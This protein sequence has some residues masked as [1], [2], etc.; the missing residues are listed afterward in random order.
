MVQNPQTNKQLTAQLGQLTTLVANLATTV[1]NLASARGS[2][3][4]PV[5]QQAA[6]TGF[7]LTPGL[8]AGDNLIDFSTKN[9]LALYKAGIEPLLTAFDLK[10]EQLVIFEKELA[11]KVSSMGWNKGA[12]HITTYKN[13]YDRTIDIMPKYGQ[14]NHLTLKATYKVFVKE[15]GTCGQQYAAENNE[16]MWHCINN[17]LTKQA[18]VNVLSNC[19][20]YEINNNRVKKIAAHLLYKIIMCLATLNSNTT[21]P[22]TLSK[23]P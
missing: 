1:Y 16:Q 15:S 18:K 13:Q 19:K 8:T 20:D 22:S 6:A 17:S 10:V 11:N 14:I 12:Q 2:N 7:T 3:P 23:P 21:G 4:P 9:R 5:A